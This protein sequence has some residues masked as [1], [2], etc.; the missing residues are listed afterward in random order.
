M[1][2]Y[3]NSGLHNTIVRLIMLAVSS[4]ESEGAESLFFSC[5]PFFEAMSDKRYL[6]EQ[7]L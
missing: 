1:F 5:L 6:S 4:G 7:N 3:V 2:S